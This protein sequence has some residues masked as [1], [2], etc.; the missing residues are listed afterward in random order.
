MDWMRWN[1]KAGVQS[2]RCVFELD[3]ALVQAALFLT[4]QGTA[5]YV[6]DTASAGAT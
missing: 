1:E 3:E 6:C 5:E 4:T 2:G